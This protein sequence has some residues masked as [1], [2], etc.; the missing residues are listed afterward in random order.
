MFSLALET[1]GRIGSVAIAKDGVVITERSYPHGL[2]HASAL[3]PL[4]DQLC[5]EYGLTPADLEEIYV[6]VGPG[7]FT[8]LRVGV[9]LA[10]S[11][12]FATGARLV[13]VPSVQVLAENAPKSAST[14]AIVLDAKRGQIFTATYARNADGALIER[15]PA[16]LA[17]L[18]TVIE[19]SPRPLHLLGD[20]IPFHR[21][22]IPID[23]Q[24]IVTNDATW[25][26]TATVVSKIGAAMA[27]RGEFA[28]VFT[29]KPTYVRLPEA[30]EKRLIAEGQL[31]ADGTKIAC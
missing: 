18:A 24:V 22:S 15:A 12:A 26:P 16:R 6:S 2:Q 23:E 29:I 14:V 1:S 7:S 13:A 30:E 5:Q 4:I 17:R 8:G 19:E 10:K 25:R 31:N 27:A 9:T 11:L 28:N 21:G 20:G 3:V